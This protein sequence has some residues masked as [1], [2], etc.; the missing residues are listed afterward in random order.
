M[1]RG[2]LLHS[3]SELNKINNQIRVELNHIR[4]TREQQ[5]PNRSPNVSK[6]IFKDKIGQ[7]CL[8]GT[9]KGA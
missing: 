8:L 1:N 5:H 6:R 7:T 2:K 4:Y 3:V 9:N